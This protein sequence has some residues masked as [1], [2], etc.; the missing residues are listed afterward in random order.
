MEM[1]D[2]I[3]FELNDEYH[4]FVEFQNIP[5]EWSTVGQPRDFSSVHLTQFDGGTPS[6]NVS[7]TLPISQLLK[8]HFKRKKTSLPMMK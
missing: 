2:K 4:I 6:I 5:T 3:V 1:W 8:T 7:K